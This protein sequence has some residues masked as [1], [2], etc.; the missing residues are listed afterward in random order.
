MTKSKRNMKPIERI[1]RGIAI[2]GCKLKLR[3]KKDAYR[4]CPQYGGTNSF[5]TV[6][7]HY[8]GFFDIGPKYSAYLGGESMVF[9]YVDKNEISLSDV[10]GL[11]RI[12]GCPNPIVIYTIISRKHRL[13]TTQTQFESV[14]EEL[15]NMREV[16]FY[17]VGSVL[18]GAESELGDGSVLG[19]QTG[20]GDGDGLGDETGLGDGV[21]LG[22]E[23]GLRDGEEL[24]VETELRDGKGLCA[25]TGLGDGDGLDAKTG[26]GD[27]EGLG[28]KTGMG[29]G[30]GL[31][32]KTGMGDGEG[33]GAKTGMG[34]G[35]G[36]GDCEPNECHEQ[37]QGVDESYI[38]EFLRELSESD[39]NDG[40]T[41][42]E[43]TDDSDD[44]LYEFEY[45]MED[46]Q[47][48][49][50]IF[51]T[52]MATIKRQQTGLKCSFCHVEGHN[53]KGC[54]L[55]KEG[56]A[57]PVAIGRENRP[58]KLQV[59]EI[60]EPAPAILT[61]ES[62]APAK[63]KSKHKPKGGQ[64]PISDSSFAD[65]I[66]PSASIFPISVVSYHEKKRASPRSIRPPISTAIELSSRI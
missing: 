49:D 16:F 61:Q 23:T 6:A 20:F 8:G 56:N 11:A 47:V 33:L 50:K 52:N 32:D 42:N 51:V 64:D 40:E 4:S 3:A 5:F 1:A 7:I 66:L 37:T 30:E 53:K 13:I 26:M 46:E 14:F 45:D 57:E 36:L 31:G 29:D 39:V 65:V 15:R 18:S 54:L 48:D 41:E 38:D 10:K 21:G 34:D 27:G 63:D 59:E 60:R 55:I 62:V 22:P 2:S 17:V 35:E 58:T 24:G 12:K 44:D 25:E 43:G 19:A 9:D 28:A